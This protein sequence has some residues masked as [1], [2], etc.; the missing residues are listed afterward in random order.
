[1]TEENVQLTV[2]TDTGNIKDLFDNPRLLGRY[3]I[4]GNKDQSDTL[5]G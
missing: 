5:I 3:K 2:I 4:A 1:M